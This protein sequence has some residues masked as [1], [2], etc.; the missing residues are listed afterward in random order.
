MF[1]A[2]I[3]TLSFLSQVFTIVFAFSVASI[4]AAAASTRQ[5]LNTM[6]LREGL[7]LAGAWESLMAFLKSIGN[8]I[9][10]FVSGKSKSS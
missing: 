10:E 2:G 9:Y 4:L 1:L 8:R 7:S 5:Q 3:L 6:F